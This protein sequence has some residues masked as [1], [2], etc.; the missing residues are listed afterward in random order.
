MLLHCKGFVGSLL[1]QGR[2]SR[3]T[4]SALDCELKRDGC[5]HGTYNTTRDVHITVYP[6]STAVISA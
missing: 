3:K 5:C 6:I 2:I 4:I 1:L